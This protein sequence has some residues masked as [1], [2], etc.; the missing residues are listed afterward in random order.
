MQNLL[1]DLTSGDPTRIWSGA[2]AV[3]RSWDLAQLGDLAAHLAEIRE[4]TTG[5]PLGGALHPN[6]AHLNDALARLEHVRD[7]RGCLCAL[8]P[9]SQFNNPGQEAERGHVQ[10]LETRLADGHYVYFYTCACLHC[11]ARYRVIERE[12]HY[13]WWGWSRL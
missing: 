13:T 11:G 6:S 4:A 2:G 1:E 12:Y 3:L 5:I 10:V 7:Q 9:S 8:Y